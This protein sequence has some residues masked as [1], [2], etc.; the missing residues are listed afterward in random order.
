MNEQ[1]I[2]TKKFLYEY[3]LDGILYGHFFHA[4]DWQQAE[5]HLDAISRNGKIVGELMETIPAH[6]G[7]AT[8][9]KF[10]VWW[11]NLKRKLLST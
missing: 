2:K 11:Q 7:T 1:T 6:P 9:A 3:R 10:Y 5:K 4:K 8:Y